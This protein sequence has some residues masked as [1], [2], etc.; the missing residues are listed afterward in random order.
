MAREIW[1]EDPN[2]WGQIKNAPQLMMLEMERRLRLKGANMVKGQETLDEQ[3]QSGVMERGVPPPKTGSLKF[4]SENE[5]TH[6]Q[7]MVSQGVYK[8]LEE[9]VRHRDQEDTGYIEINRTPDF[10]KK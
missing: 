5:K 2:G 9:Y 1:N 7:R 4:N 10:T 6:A 3:D 8:S